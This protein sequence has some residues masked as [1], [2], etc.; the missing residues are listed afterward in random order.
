MFTIVMM[1][2]TLYINAIYSKYLDLFRCISINVNRV[3]KN[4]VIL[5]LHLPKAI[6]RRLS[7][8]QLLQ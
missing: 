6:V 2:S 7:K 8:I 3:A 4:S 1:D 5:Y